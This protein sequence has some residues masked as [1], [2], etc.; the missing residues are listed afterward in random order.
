[1]SDAAEKM[2]ATTSFVAFRPAC[3]SKADQNVLKAFYDPNS[4]GVCMPMLLSELLM[5]AYLTSHFFVCAFR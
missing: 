1:M 4:P 3:S 2:M 5:L